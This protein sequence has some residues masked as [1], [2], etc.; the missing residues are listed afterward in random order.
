MVGV[1]PC[2]RCVVLYYH[3]VTPQLRRRFARQLDDMLQFSQ[4]IPLD[5]L[6]RFERGERYVAVTFDDGLCCVIE[7]A[8][9]ELERRAIPST[10]FIVAGVLGSHPAWATRPTDDFAAHERVASA[11]QLIGLSALVTIGSHTL[12]HP[13]L[14]AT[15]EAVA[16]RELLDSRRILE[17]LLGK[18]ITLFSFPYGAFSP[19][20][21]SWC[22][23]AGYF[24]VFTTQ[25]F[26][27][28]S[29]RHER[30]TGRVPASPADWRLEFRLKVLGAYRWLPYVVAFKQQL[31][32]YSARLVRIGRR[33]LHPTH[34][35]NLRS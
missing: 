17:S 21:V 9:P 28:F 7:N 34:F 27:A 15:R 8:I 13:L 33:T 35:N 20:L 5:R 24:R 18:R 22:L 3:A 30:V 10:H 25:P 23:D 26:L 14:T 11:A 32:N 12:T 16:R 6:P 1:K 31:V 2:G 4:P 19:E 29:D